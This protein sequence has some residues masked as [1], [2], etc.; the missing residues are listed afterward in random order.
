[1]TTNIILGVSLSMLYAVQ[2]LIAIIF[3]FSFIPFPVSEYTQHFFP[4]YRTTLQPER[5]MLFFRCFVVLACAFHVAGLFM[6]RR[7]LDGVHLT[8]RL[9][10]ICFWEGS[11]TAAMMVAG[12]LLL[13]YPQAVFKIGLA[14]FLL[15]A[16]LFKASRPLVLS[17]GYP[18][19]R[20]FLRRGL[21]ALQVV[22]AEALLA[23]IGLIITMQ[24]GLLLRWR[25]WP[26]WVALLVGPAVFM[27]LKKLGGRPGAWSGLKDFLLIDGI[28][29]LLLAQ[30]A[31]N[32]HTHPDRPLL[33]QRLFRVLTAALIVHKIFFPEIDRLLRRVWQAALRMSPPSWVRPDLVLP[34]FFVL[35]VY[36]PDYEAALARMFLGEQFHHTNAF[37]MCSGWAHISGCILNVDVISRYGTGVVI[38]LS[39]IAH[40]FFGGYS[41]ESVFLVVMWGVM[42]YYVLWYFLMRR[43]FQSLA[44]TVIGMLLAIK[45]QMFHTET[46]PFIYTY[47]NQTP[48]RCFWDVVTAWCILRHVETH[49]SRWLAAAGI[50]CGWAIFYTTGDGVYLTMGYGGYLAGQMLTSE[51]RSYVLFRGRWG[52]R[53]L[54]LYLG[55]PVVSALAFF[56]A[57]VGTHMLTAQFWQNMG[58]FMKYYSSGFGSTPMASSWVSGNY[59]EFLIGASLPMFY[60]ATLLI[61]GT[62]LFFRK[63]E[64]K[65][66]FIIFIAVYALG[67]YHYYAVLSNNTSY[68]RNGVIIA[69]LLCF[70]GW[71]GFK[72]WPARRVRK[73]QLVLMAVCLYALFTHHNFVAFPNIFNV[74]SKPMI[75]PLVA[76]VPEG[77]KSYFNHLFISYPDA[78]KLPRNS[79]GET[80]EQLVTE[81]DFKSHE[82]LKEFY[83]REFDFTKDARLIDG[84]VPPDGKVALISSFE[85]KILIQA[86]R[87]PFFY[88]FE[89]VNSR[90]RRMR[91]FVVTHLYTVDNLQRTLSQLEAEKPEYIFLERIFLAKQI[92]QAYLYDSMNL[93][94]LLEYVFAHYE[95]FKDGE[96]LAALK[97]K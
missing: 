94:M 7:E 39:E 89:M 77:R 36:V 91:I 85:T 97:R 17:W 60:T 6:S 82:D 12:L 1:M 34:V 68:Y 26:V 86:K 65:Q 63:M 88:Y 83:R 56:A 53:A 47:S 13:S 20:H 74:S 95:H 69:F 31:W 52:W 8:A 21:Q 9:K 33:A 70:W 87:K 96:F 45:W 80:D 93:T 51:G 30:A 75:D 67:A 11:L 43:W 61:V 76:E 46:F 38:M 48:I 28:L 18:K 16:V 4:M 55:L 25:D 41:Y 40:R 54:L 27:V 57:A 24:V 84:L 23:G 19:P 50:T 35:L 58:E 49:R 15:V 81:K 92:P 66:S 72:D 78:F 37:I 10:R 90:P 71:Y 44:W 22:P 14:L 5:D 3:L 29:T 79:V 59:L 64:Y 62:F 2:A 32:I 42:L 73:I